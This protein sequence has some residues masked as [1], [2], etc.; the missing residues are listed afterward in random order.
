MN[1]EADNA[2]FYGRPKNLQRIKLGQTL[3][4]SQFYILLDL[5]M[6]PQ[7]QHEAA[8]GRHSASTASPV[9]GVYSVNGLFGTEN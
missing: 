3:V 7:Y 9:V 5:K 6:Q 1:L 8:E 2:E 4:P